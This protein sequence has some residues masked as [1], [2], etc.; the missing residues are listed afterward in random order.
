MCAP[1]LQQLCSLSLAGREGTL[2]SWIVAD[3]EPLI[4]MEVQDILSEAGFQV[5]TAAKAEE[6]LDI[7]IHR[8]PEIDLFLPMSR[9]RQGR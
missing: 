7:L 3:D 4:R 9:C 8:S 1:E 2:R 6:A 5:L